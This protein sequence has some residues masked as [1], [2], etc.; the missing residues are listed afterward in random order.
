MN[1]ELFKALLLKFNE[2]ESR[3][4]SNNNNY[5][6][7]VNLFNQVRNSK[8]IGSEGDELFN[9]EADGTTDFNFYQKLIDEQLQRSN[10]LAPA[11]GDPKRGSNLG[12]NKLFMSSSNPILIDSDTAS[13]DSDTEID[14]LGGLSLWHLT[15]ILISILIFTGK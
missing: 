3:E 12:L 2:D 6:D 11:V 13:F 10:T 14:Y 8:P 15:A 5:Y 1:D 7:L 9:F 4:N